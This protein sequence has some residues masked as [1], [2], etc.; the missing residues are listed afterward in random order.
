MSNTSQSECR[1]TIVTVTYNS[2]A[3][4]PDMLNSLPDGVPCVVVDNASDNHAALA[5]LVVAHRAQLIR[6]EDN[7]GFGVACN[8][9]AAQAHTEFLL[10]LNPDARLERGALEELVGCADANP[11]AVAFNPAISEANGKTYFKRGSVLLPN[12]QKLP[13]G[14]PQRDREVPVLSGA[15]FFVRRD[16]FE[17]V[18][19]FDPAIFLYHEDDDLALRLRAQCGSLMFVR[20]AEVTHDSG[21]STPKSPSS[22]ALKAYHMGRSRVYAARKHHLPGAGRKALQSALLQMVSP[23][24]LL[25]KRKR[26]KQ[27]AFLRGVLTSIRHKAAR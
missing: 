19:G 27:I 11:A 12:A 24:T 2:L 16:S 21:N 23:L 15:A 4:L 6:N 17:A 25:S 13:P 8:I 14:W 18:G 26:A 1:V 5:E 20:G 7:C 10:F 22:A 3:V 9:G